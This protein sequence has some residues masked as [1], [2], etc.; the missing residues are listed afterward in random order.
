MLGSL[1]DL[2]RLVE[3]VYGGSQKPKPFQLAHAVRYLRS[4]KGAGDLAKESGTTERRLNLLGDAEDPVEAIF[5]TTLAEAAKED[6]M[7]KAMQGLGQML[8]GGLA[9]R[10]FVTIY[11]QT[12]GTTELKLED[13]RASRNETDYRVLNGSGRPVFRINIKFHGSP[14]RKAVELVHLEP[15]DCFALATY[16]IWQ[17]IRKQDEERLPYIFAV[18]GVPNLTRDVV[19]TAMPEDLVHLAAL[20]STS[21]MSGKRDVEDRI[22]DFL[23]EKPPSAAAGAIGKFAKQIE[24]AE[25][26]ILSARRAGNLLRE[27]LFDRV[28]ALR[29]RAFARNYRGAEVDMHFSISKE[30]TP[31]HEF[32][33]LIKE[34]GLQGISTRLERGEI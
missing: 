16:K 6:P 25:W 14:F 31:L 30:L 20:T 19:G 26:R 4:G 29:V 21:K 22:V 28:Y 11:K 34:H 15:A 32:L 3:E 33:G 12:L 10:A 9:E 1:E 7:K 24:N 23:L 18:V 13:F 17:G 2:T 5:K 27:N 8:I